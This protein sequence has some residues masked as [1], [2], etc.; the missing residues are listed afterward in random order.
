LAYSKAPKYCNRGYPIETG[1]PY[2]EGI[3]KGLR[4]RLEDAKENL[5][6][7]EVKA[8][9]EAVKKAQVAGALGTTR[10]LASS[11]KNELPADHACPYCA[12]EL[13]ADCNADHIYPVS[14]GGQSR[15]ENMVNVC[16]RC[17]SKK[18][19][20]TL[21]RYIQK[22]KLDRAAIESRLKRLGKEF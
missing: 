1:G 22:H 14:K 6:R 5:S 19:N 16:A 4:I 3:I 17:N 8:A 10:N 18:S 13:G 7:L 21:N 20:M 11:I 9:R 2:I 15:A 12:G